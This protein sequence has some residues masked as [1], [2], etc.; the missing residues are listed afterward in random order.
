MTRWLE[1]VLAP[2]TLGQFLALRAL[3]RESLEAGELARRAGVTA[4]AM[5]QLVASLEA[6]GLVERAAL[7]DRRR[8]AIRPTDTGRR[9]LADATASARAALSP[10]VGRLPKPEQHSVQRA[11]QEIEAA[12]AG[13]PPPPRPGPRRPPGPPHR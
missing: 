9:V 12:L 1:R 8:W 5:S 10:V 2:L 6:G 4:A 3:A 13:T 7:E 11:L